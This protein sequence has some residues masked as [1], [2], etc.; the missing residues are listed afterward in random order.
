MNTVTNSQKEV[1]VRG[2]HLF[3]LG[4]TCSS[5][6]VLR[7][8]AGLATVSR[9]VPLLFHCTSTAGNCANNTPL[10]RLSARVLV[11]QN[12]RR[13]RTRLLAKDHAVFHS[14]STLL[15]VLAGYLKSPSQPVVKLRLNIWVGKLSR[16]IFLNFKL[17]FYSRLPVRNIHYV[18]I[19]PVEQKGF[20]PLQYNM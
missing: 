7:P 10:L 13:S 11:L 17:V 5:T 15:I 8:V 6:L 18:F 9:H 20:I 12:T 16:F 4:V 1:K 14:G 3:V 2:T 19:I